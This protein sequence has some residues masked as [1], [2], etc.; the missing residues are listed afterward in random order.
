LD[1]NTPRENDDIP[2][3]S[4][5]KPTNKSSTRSSRRASSLVPK[6]PINRSRID[7]NSSSASLKHSHRKS[8]ATSHKQFGRCSHC[9][10]C[11]RV[12]NQSKSS[13]PPIPTPKWLTENP[14]PDQVSINMDDYDVEAVKKKIISENGHLPGSYDYRPHLTIEQLSDYNQTKENYYTQ[15]LV[16]NTQPRISPTRTP[17]PE[18][19]LLQRLE[20]RLNKPNTLKLFD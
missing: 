3:S 17:F 16:A 6:S 4:I 2:L 8:S 11:Q 12:N 15:P 19:E 13:I 7:S 5:E 14:G 20:Q 18:Y 1:N 9:P 10:H